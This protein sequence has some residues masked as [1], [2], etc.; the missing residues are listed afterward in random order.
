MLVWGCFVGRSI[1]S[2]LRVGRRS[3]LEQGWVAGCVQPIFVADLHQGSLHFLL[4]LS[5]R[6]QNFNRSIVL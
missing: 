2:H 1:A 3:K 4:L 6:I 5:E